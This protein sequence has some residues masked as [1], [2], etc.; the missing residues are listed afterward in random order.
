MPSGASHTA[1]VSPTNAN[2]PFVLEMANIGVK[3]ALQQQDDSLAAGVKVCA[4][5]IVHPDVAAS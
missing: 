3:E 4:G 2:L 5:S 1:T